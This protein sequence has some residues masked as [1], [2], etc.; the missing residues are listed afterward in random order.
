MCGQERPRSVDTKREKY[1]DVKT[2]WAYGHVD[3]DDDDDDEHPLLFDATV[4][5]FISA[6]MHACILM[7]SC[8]C[9]CCSELNSIQR[10]ESMES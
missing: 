2:F 10:Q 1:N 9:C 8:C 7:S 6:C 3:D 4:C 5:A